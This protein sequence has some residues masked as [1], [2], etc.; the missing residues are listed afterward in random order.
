MHVNNSANIMN[1][2]FDS[3][4]WRQLRQH[5]A[6]QLPPTFADDVLRSVRLQ[7]QATHP[8]AWLTPF[9]IAA[10]T[11]AVCLLALVAVHSSTTSAMSDEHLADWMEIS[12]QSASLALNP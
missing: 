1:T 12:T 4:S 6:A 9:G 8:L 5:A 11:A 7:A 2:P 10:V 3:H